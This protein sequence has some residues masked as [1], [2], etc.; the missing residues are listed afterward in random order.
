MRPMTVKLMQFITIVLVALVV[1]VFWGPWLGLSRSIDA[2]TPETFLAIGH[3]M[4]GNLAPVMPVLV[5][6]AAAS[7]LVLVALLYRQRST[8]FP[9]MAIGFALFLV[10]LLVT[11]LVEVPIDN[12]IK[13]W[14]IDSLPA[15][16]MELRDQWERFH[17]LR[18]FSALVGLTM[19]VAATVFGR[20]RSSTG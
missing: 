2:F 7:Q 8:G 20:P 15:N 1:G 14:T 12:Q 4:I 16:W 13:A 5:L 18:T 6:L 10:A 11:L 17:V 19:V 3:T 9:A